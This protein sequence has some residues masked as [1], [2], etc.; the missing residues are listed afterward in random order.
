M[1]SY[2]IHK[3][4][5]L[6]S[7]VN[8]QKMIPDVIEFDLYGSR[9]YFIW[10]RDFKSSKKDVWI[11]RDIYDYLPYL[12][13]KGVDEVYKLLKIDIHEPPTPKLPQ[14][15]IDY[16]AKLISEVHP[17]WETRAHRRDQSYM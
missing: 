2:Y 13:A 16:L 12:L 10:L 9:D 15:K 8:T 5:L 7:D 17:N 6:Y 3:K 4:E 1:K 14:Y 11:Y